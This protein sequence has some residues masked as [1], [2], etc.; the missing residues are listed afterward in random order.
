MSREPQ[1]SRAS[2][3][4]RQP[5][6]TPDFEASL[7]K[8][9][10]LVNAMEEG[11]LSLEESLQAFET[12]IQLTRECQTALQKAEQKVQILMESDAEPQALEPV[13]SETGS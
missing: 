3:E 11:D 2:R 4:P 10:E 6:N 1:E 12:G 5:E 8:L 7:Q 13:E 9:E